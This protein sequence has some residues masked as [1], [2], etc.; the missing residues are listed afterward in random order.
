MDK[1]GRLMP[2]D[3]PQTIEPLRLAKTGKQIVGQYELCTMQR[4]GALLHENTG[5]VSFILDFGRDAENGFY[6]ITGEV[7]TNLNTVCQRCLEGLNI[8]ISSPVR[9]GIAN[10]KTEAE[11]LPSGYEPLLISDDPVSL[12]E[13]IEDELLLA[14][15]IAPMH[16]EKECHAMKQLMGHYNT[17][18]KKPFAIL[19][20]LI[21]KS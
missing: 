2:P 5:Y 20:N 3:L 4:L 7:N 12:L 10:N 6:C 9:L 15:P 1:L 14:M 17:E 13:L 16:D 19:E 11:N 18:T 8:Q 21:K